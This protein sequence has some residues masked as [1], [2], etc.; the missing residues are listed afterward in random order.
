MCQ[1]HVGFLLLSAMCPLCVGFLPVL[2]NVLPACWICSSCVQSSSPC[3]ISTCSLCCMSLTS[4]IS[5]CHVL[6]V[7]FLW[8][9]TCHLQWI[10]YLLDFHLPFVMC[11]LLV[12]CHVP[13]SE[14]LW[15]VG[16]WPAIDSASAKCCMC[17]YCE[18]CVAYGLDFHLQFRMCM[19]CVVFP[20]A[21]YTV[22]SLSWILPAV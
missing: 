11:P 3:R 2:Y 14:C 7:C 4:W 18:H 1:F 10:C 5:T 9:S 12:E 21:V 15:R 8:I 17:T 22:F 6:C 16:F 20:F 13:C 19:L